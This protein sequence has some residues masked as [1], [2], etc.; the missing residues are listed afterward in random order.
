MWPDVGI[1][2]VCDFHVVL[3]KERGI[4][5]LPLL[6]DCWTQKTVQL[7]MDAMAGTGA[8]I[9]DHEMESECSGC[10]KMR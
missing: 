1:R 5:S 7:I 10:E 9:L 2:E 8:A 6:L 4:P 3:L